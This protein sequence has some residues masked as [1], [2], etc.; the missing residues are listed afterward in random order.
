MIQDEIIDNKSNL[1]MISF[2]VENVIC[3][4]AG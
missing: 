4:P 3:R 2:R 1:N